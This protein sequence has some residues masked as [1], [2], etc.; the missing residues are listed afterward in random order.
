MHRQ[1]SLPLLCALT[2]LGCDGKQEQKPTTAK[3]SASADK[4]T[5][6]KA[7]AKADE[8]KS[9]ATPDAVRVDAT[10]SDDTTVD[11]TTVDDTTAKPPT[12]D[13]GRDPLP[14]M[15]AYGWHDGLAVDTTLMTDAEAEAL[16]KALDKDGGDEFE[17]RTLP[18]ALVPRALRGLKDVTVVDTSGHAV[19]KV[20]GFGALAGPGETHLKILLD[21]AAK[22]DEQALVLRHAPKNDKLKLEELKPGVTGTATTT[23]KVADAMQAHFKAKLPDVKEGLAKH[24]VSAKD[25]LAIGGKFGPGQSV[26]FQITWPKSHDDEGHLAQASAVVL[27]D[28]TGKIASAPYPATPWVAVKVLHVIDLDADGIDEI[29][30]DEHWME[31]LYTKMLR[32]DAKTKAY[33]VLTL[34][35]DAA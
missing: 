35:G 5:N 8:T 21:R 15:W 6:A 4:P 1:A 28:A 14:P 26:A 31:G 11:D 22:G 29:I 17:L 32:W 34:T 25:V 7:D 18:E 3:A 19:V 24:P 16:Q 10:G 12:A 13:A 23:R 2:L 20:K 9:D 27:M 30:L 33:E